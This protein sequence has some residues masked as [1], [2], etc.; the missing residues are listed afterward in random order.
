MKSYVQLFQVFI[1]S[2]CVICCFGITA[3]QAETSSHSLMRAKGEELATATGHY[4]RS[5]SL[6]LAA[7]REFDLGLKQAN[8]NML[9]DVKEWREDLINRAEDLERVL[10]PQ[11]R[12]TKH[13]VQFRPNH[14]LLGEAY[15]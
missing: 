1:T 11:P 7:L 8:P 3:L 2:F 4:A 15:R 13:G 10:T 14:E 5:R 9:L 6:L 12:S